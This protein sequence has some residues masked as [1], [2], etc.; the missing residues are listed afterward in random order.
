MFFDGLIK[1]NRPGWS[2][3]CLE[4]FTYPPDRRLCVIF[5][6]KEY[7]KR[8]VR[9]RNNCNKLFINYIKLFGPFTKDT[10]SRWLKNV[11]SR[12]GIDINTVSAHS[13][14]AA[15]T[16]KA[17]AN[18]VPVDNILKVAGWSNAETFARFYKKPIETAK[19]GY[20]K[21]VLKL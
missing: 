5:V 19:S 9:L 10:I 7:L 17:Y 12:S 2:E 6:L 14:R 15:S 18:L 21:A 8:T 16:S 11:M 3:N 13:V 20:Q 4:F 1:Q